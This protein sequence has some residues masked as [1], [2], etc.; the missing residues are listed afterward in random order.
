MNFSFFEG[1]W[2]N[3]NEESL[4]L[5]PVTPSKRKDPTTVIAGGGGEECGQETVRLGVLFENCGTRL[6]ALCGGRGG[7]GR[8]RRSG[9]G[10]R[11]GARD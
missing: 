10:R 2:R 8:K 11:M 7:G 1:R 5:M 4:A 6:R 9:V 3:P